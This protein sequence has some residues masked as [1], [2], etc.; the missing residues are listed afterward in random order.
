MGKKITVL[1]ILLMLAVLAVF[2]YVLIPGV[3]EKAASYTEE[4]FKEDNIYT[5][6]SDVSERLQEEIEKGSDSFVVYI[7][8]MAIEDLSE[9]NSPLDGIWGSGSSYQQIGR[10]GDNY[11]KIK[12][13]I[14]KS[15]NYYAVQAYLQGTPIPESDERAKR[16]YDVIVKIMSSFVTAEMSDYEKEVA[17]HDYLV[18]HCTYSEAEDWPSESDVFRAYGALVNGEAVCNGYA[19]ALQILFTCAGISSKFVIGMAGDVEHAWNL[20]E[21]DGKWYHLDAT[22][23]D[24]LPD[25]GETVIHTYVNLSDEEISVAH[26]WNREDYPKAESEDMNYYRK[27]N[28]YF[29]SFE[30]YKEQAYDALIRNGQQ[31]YEAAVVTEPVQDADMQ[32]LFEGESVYN[33]ASWKCYDESGYKVLIVGVGNEGY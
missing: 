16:L 29:Q 18:R 30:E 9:L 20:V 1:A 7:K 25:Q 2:G 15:S 21:L 19:E 6:I 23:D 11:K 10:V 26:T 33:S 13:T 32:F 8:D 17:L 22:W 5:D 12:I 31:Y 27:T 14:E 24:P 4:D 3:R 28:T